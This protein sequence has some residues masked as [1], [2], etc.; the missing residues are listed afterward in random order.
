MNYLQSTND[1][2][3]SKSDMG[4][5][6]YQSVTNHRIDN[7]APFSGEPAPEQDITYS[8]SGKITLITEYDNGLPIKNLSI[9]Y[10]VDDQRFKSTY[11][12][13]GSPVYS[14][15]FI[16]NYEKEHFSDGTDRH[17][18]YIYALGHLIGVYE[19]TSSNS[20]MHYIYEDHLG[21]IRCITDD[22]A[23]VEKG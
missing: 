14:R 12:V 20:S 4:P 6:E 10:G 22:I 15:Y 13:E 2:I 9:E 11:S 21:S 8:A 18:N 7:I 23:N 3:E 5:Y 16:N 19:Q 17:L 1:R